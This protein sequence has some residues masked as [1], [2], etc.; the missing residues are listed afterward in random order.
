[1]KTTEQTLI[2]KI[3]NRNTNSADVL[4]GP[5]TP[6]SRSERLFPVP[7][8]YLL[9]VLRKVDKICRDEIEFAVV[10]LKLKLP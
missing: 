9:P 8:D 10:K 6:S 4:E 7:R 1:M 5:S 3:K 2:I